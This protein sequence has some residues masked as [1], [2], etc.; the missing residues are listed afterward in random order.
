[1]THAILTREDAGEVR[2]QIEDSLRTLRARQIN[3]IPVFC[4]PNGDYTD[5]IAAVV[6]ASGYAGAVCSQPG[7]EAAT[8]RNLFAI[9]RIGVHN[10]I[11]STIPLFAFNL[12]RRERLPSVG[13]RLQLSTTGATG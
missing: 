1:V 10:D 8:P 7:W 3:H 6:T 5:E 11:A 4:Y 2:R 12:F 13:T 9:R